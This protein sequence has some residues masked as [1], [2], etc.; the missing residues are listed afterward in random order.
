[1]NTR[2]RVPQKAM[3]AM[4]LSVVAILVGAFFLQQVFEKAERSTARAQCRESIQSNS[5]LRL[6]GF[7]FSS[8]INCP[9]QEIIATGNDDEILGTV[10]DELY[11]CWNQWGAGQLELF[12]AEDSVFCA[13]CSVIEFDTKDRKIPGVLTTLNSRIIPGGGQS[14]YEYLTGVRVDEG[15]SQRL[16]QLADS[17]KD[18]IDTSQ[19]MSIV[20]TYAKDSRVTKQ[21]GLIWGLGI[22]SAVGLIAGGI[23]AIVF[24]PA[25]IAVL[26]VTIIS[27]TTIAVT[28]AAATTLA[29]GATGGLIG[30][31]LGHDT[32]A[33]WDARII[34]VP[35]NRDQ[36]Q[37]RLKCTDFPV[38][39]TA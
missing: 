15:L 31:A 1:M 21:Q 7:D 26:S 28:T 5:Q 29:A 6:Y 14:Y 23:L 37:D 25:G 12:K 13:V 4:I 35:Y 18:I 16:T 9:T 33:N 20:F 36:L 24:P 17:E 3:V 32:S 8:R 10:A 11:S 38:S 2:G 34:A 19:D 39:Q 27:A 22:G 30:Y